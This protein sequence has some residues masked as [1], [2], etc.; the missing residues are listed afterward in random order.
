MTR[1]V[2][3]TKQVKQPVKTHSLM[4][5]GSC[6]SEEDAARLAELREMSSGSTWI[7]T[8]QSGSAP[9]L[10]SENK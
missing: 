2:A 9:T 6:G 10:D 8:L 7:T 1:I 4:S 3:I 5:T